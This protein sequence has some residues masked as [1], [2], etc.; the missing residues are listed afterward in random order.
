MLK[1]RK[2]FIFT[3]IFSLLGSIVSLANTKIYQDESGEW[4]QA[5]VN[6]GP[7]YPG[8]TVWPE[9]AY[10]K[11]TS[12]STAGV[13]KIK[14]PSA[15]APMNISLKS[16]DQSHY[17]RSVTLNRNYDGYFRNSLYYMTSNNVG[18]GF[19]VYATLS[20][21]ALVSSAWVKGYMTP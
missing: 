19:K 11:E 4:W 3:M 8:E 9:Y 18:Y 6:V 1:L 14:G 12:D 10:A 7:I 15:Y 20:S 17:T 13:T 2:I 5:L 16:T 21:T